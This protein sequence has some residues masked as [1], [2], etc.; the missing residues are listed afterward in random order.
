MEAFTLSVVLGVAAGLLALLLAAFVLRVGWERRTNRI[1]PARARLPG[2][3]A[4]QAGAGARDGRGHR[5]GGAGL[6][7]G[8]V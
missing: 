1:R 8:D 4:G 5:G 6:G 7:P 3:A 2:P